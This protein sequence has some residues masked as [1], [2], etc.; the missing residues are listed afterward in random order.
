[1]SARLGRYFWS[2]A[3]PA[4]TAPKSASGPM[5]VVGR[6]NAGSPGGGPEAD[7]TT[8]SRYSSANSR[9]SRGAVVMTVGGTAKPLRWATLNCQGFSRAWSALRGWF[10]HRAAAQWSIPY[11]ACRVSAVSHGEGS[12]ACAAGS[13]GLRTQ[14]ERRPPMLSTCPLTDRCPSKS[15]WA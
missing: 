11:S 13:P 5:R 3:G 6:V 15:P 4:A 1:M 8:T 14:M 10:I 7:F 12:A 2:N 9:A